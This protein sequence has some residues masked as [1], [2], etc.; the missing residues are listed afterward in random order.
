MTPLGGLAAAGATLSLGVLAA[1][2]WISLTSGHDLNLVSGV[3]LALARDLREGLLYRDLLGPAGYGGTRYF[4]LFFAL[5][6]GLSRLGVDP[7]AAGHAVSLAGLGVLAAGASALLTALGLPRKATILAAVLATAPYFVQ[8]SALSIRVEPFAA[9]L[10]LLGLAAASGA[11][12]QARGSWR[13]AT[14][15]AVCFTLAIAAKPTSVYAPAAALLALVFAGRRSDA[16]RLGGATALGVLLLVSVVE[17]L[18]AGRF[19]ASVRATALAGETPAGLL[20]SETLVRPLALI[21][22]SRVLTVMVLLAAAALVSNAARWRQLP[23]LALPAAAATTALALGTPGTIL[24]NQVVELYAVLVV[25]LAWV[26]ATRPRV[27]RPGT[28]ALA[29]LLFW[30]SVQNAARIIEI[31]RATA[32]ADLGSRRAA[33][34]EAV[35]QC[36]R[37]VLAE[38]PLVPIL[39]GESPVLL[40]PFAFRVVALRTPA[41]ADDLTARIEA[42]RFTCIVIDHD[43]AAPRGAAW[44]RNVH[45][46]APVIETI[47]RHYEYRASAG[48]HRFYL[49]DGTD[50]RA[51]LGR[52][53]GR[54]LDPAVP[55]FDSRLGPRGHPGR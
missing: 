7:I 41:L 11:A 15:A 20:A 5:I 40:D 36:G 3:W 4:P 48:G 24:A 29:I 45:L 44:Y 34:R 55:A 54:P 42:R 19:L 43:P 37:P 39:A 49:P 6:A 18:S 16:L 47:L 21:A 1:H 9:G 28:V 38:S 25:F 10:A 23:V 8:Q 17:W 13:G 52:I 51:G 32:D 14:G 2:A 33:V 53:T 22:S 50:E 27:A 46:G 31:R 35:R 30:T 26:A 12:G